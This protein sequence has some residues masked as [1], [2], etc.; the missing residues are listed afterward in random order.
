MEK[1]Q[2][3]II[4]EN[5][6]KRITYPQGITLKEVAEEHSTGLKY[7][8]LG[9]KVN[10]ILKELS[11][12][13]YKPKT[14]KFIDITDPDGKRMYERSLSFILY[15][16]VKD[17]FPGSKL[18]ID[19]AISKGYYCEISNVE[20]SDDLVH[21]LKRR[22][23]EIVNHDYPIIRREML[24]DE[25][26]SLFEKNGLPEKTKIFKTKPQLYSSVYCLDNCIDYYFGHLVPSTGYIN[27]FDIEKYFDGLLLRVPRNDDPEQLADLTRQDKLFEIFREHKKWAHILDIADLGNLN[28]C[29]IN[30]KIGEI[31][32]ISEALHEKKIAQ[33]ADVIC[34][35]KDKV[36]L[37]LISGPSSS[38]KTTF[39]KRL[40]VHLQVEGL[41]P[42]AISLDNYF[43]DRELTPKDETGDYD[44]EALE[45]IDIP[46]FNK[47]LL[48]LMAGKA[49]RLPKFDFTSG[50]RIYTDK[51]LKINDETIIIVEGIHG[52]NPGLTLKIPEDMKFKIYVSAMTQISFDGHNRIPTTDNRLLRRMVRDHKFRSYS[53]LDTIKRWQS[54]RKG[55]EKNIFPYQENADI[56]FNSALIYE[57]GVIKNQ[58]EPL[59]KQIY[60]KDPEH[61]EA[62][63]LLKFLS[64]FV[65][66]ETEEIPPT[67]IL[68]EFLGGSSFNY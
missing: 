8:V 18:R 60:Q 39:S 49:V 48:D 37:I 64:Y 3:E 24:T 53:A 59:L 15:K 23:K 11:H 9:A 67:S 52:L 56:M 62:V 7:P 5:S 36:K 42:V 57:L 19:H 35:K 68:R 40:S 20:I 46:L 17:L 16:A 30:K 10:N 50:K 63:R 26:V 41:K 28:E 4:C 12:T 21:K 38:G 14:I 55:E 22:M 33:I 54:V 45:A 65:P 58:A 25:A 61:A 13:I 1:N 29:I 32:K 51:S 43:V 47:N 27:K 66:I 34:N 6:G 44:F 2:I 31:I